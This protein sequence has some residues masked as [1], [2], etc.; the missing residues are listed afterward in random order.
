MK[1]AFELTFRSIKS[2]IA[3]S[4]KPVTFR[5]RSICRRTFLTGLSRFHGSTQMGPSE[6][7]VLLGAAFVAVDIMRSGTQYRLSQ[8]MNAFFNFQLFKPASSILLL[9]TSIFHF[10]KLRIEPATFRSRGR[11]AAT[12]V[13]NNSLRK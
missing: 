11:C 5:P 13:F 12:V 6:R 7:P 4:S 2:L 8:N 1:G 10:K 9:P 3:P